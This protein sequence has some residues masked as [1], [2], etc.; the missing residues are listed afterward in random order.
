MHS[1]EVDEQKKEEQKIQKTTTSS[2]SVFATK[3][4]PR[5]KIRATTAP[6]SQVGTSPANCHQGIAPSLSTGPS[7]HFNPAS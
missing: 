7:G 1:Q 4:T 5:Y 2:Q 6:Q 3:R